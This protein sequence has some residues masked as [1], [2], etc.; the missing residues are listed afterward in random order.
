M[1]ELF[2]GQ[3]EKVLSAPQRLVQQIVGRERRGR[4][5]QG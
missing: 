4:E 5:K 1:I 2:R 3:R